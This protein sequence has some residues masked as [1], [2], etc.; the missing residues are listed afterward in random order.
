VHYIELTATVSPVDAERAAEILRS[1][2]DSGTWIERP[3]TQTTLEDAA[4]TSD[5]APARIHVYFRGPDAAAN[6]RLAPAALRAAGVE[7]T[8][9]FREVE[10]ADWAESWKEHFHVERYGEYIVVVPSWRSYDPRPGDIIITLDPGMAFGTGQHETT[11]MCL[12]ALERAVKPGVRVLDVGCGSGILSIAAAKLGAASVLALDIDPDCV[13]ITRENAERNSCADLIDA[14]RGS[15]SSR[16]ALGGEF[17]VIVANIIAGTIIDLASEFLAVL[18]PNGR[19][20][21]SGI[22]GER[23]AAV[24]AALSAGGMRIDSVRT[25]GEWRCVEA[26]LR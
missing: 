12:E 15:L 4:V 8:C 18:A 19:L 13:R 7:A 1:L 5:D 22:I 20:V 26:V 24:T 14:R 23:E 6:A 9:D 21:A 25:M 3:F 2:A 16:Y 11:R 17:D 10:D